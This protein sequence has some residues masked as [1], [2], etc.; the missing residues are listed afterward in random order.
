MPT[1]Y[2]IGW[3]KKG[4]S[5]KVT[6]LCYVPLS[7]G[8]TYHDSIICDIVDMDA[9]HVLLGWSWQYDVNAT[10]GGKKNEYSFV[11]KNKKIILPPIPP[12]PKNPKDQKPKRISLC[13]KGEF[14]TESKELKQRFALVVKEEVNTILE[15]PKKMK[16]LLTEFE[17]LVPEELPEGLPPMRDIQHHINFIPGSDEKEHMSHLR[18][19]FQVLKENELYINLKKCVFLTTQ[20]IFLGFV[21]KITT[22]PILAFP[23]FDKH[24]EL[25]C[26]A[27]GVG[28][29]EILSQEKRPFAFLSEKLNEA[30]QKWSTYKQ[31]LYA[32]FH[33]L[34]T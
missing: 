23:D 25:E 29:R 14:L 11:W 28:I 17:V 15:V 34:K 32:V 16:S 22:A 13:N 30:R 6:E 24:F 4:P 7:P 1:P 5:V 31:E 3:I 2:T 26:D 9:C 27:C 20:L 10:H 19:V 18:E 21:E 12:S 8:K 33:S